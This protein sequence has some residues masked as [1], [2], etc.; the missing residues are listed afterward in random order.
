MLSNVGSLFLCVPFLLPRHHTSKCCIII[1][2]HCYCH[3]VALL[4]CDVLSNLSILSFV[5]LC[6][7]AIVLP[8]LGPDYMGKIAP[9]SRGRVFAEIP[10]LRSNHCKLHFDII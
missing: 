8:P 7:H 10:L 1:I 5:V 2:S 3:H 6:Y 9:S 4:I